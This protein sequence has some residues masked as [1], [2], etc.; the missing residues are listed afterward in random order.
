MSFH[1][2]CMCCTNLNKNTEK[3]VREQRQSY[4]VSLQKPLPAEREIL[5]NQKKKKF[6]TG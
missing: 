1:F 6:L 3:N 4:I 5:P 2:V